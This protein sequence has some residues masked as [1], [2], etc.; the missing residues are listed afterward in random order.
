[1]NNI[2]EN[3]AGVINAGAYYLKSAVA[4]LTSN[5]WLLGLS[6]FMLL[7]AGKSLKL[8]KILNIKG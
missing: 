6:V 2:I 5:A 7:A 8:G 3:L 1:M 4:L